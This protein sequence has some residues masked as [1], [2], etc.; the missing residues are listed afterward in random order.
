MNSFVPWGI[1]NAPRKTRCT[2]STTQ[3]RIR[4][5]SIMDGGHLVGVISIGDPVKAIIDEQK[6]IIEQLERYISG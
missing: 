3:K 4:H 1:A 5:L 2:R 6:F